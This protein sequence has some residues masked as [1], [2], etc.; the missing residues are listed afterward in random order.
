M[1]LN[2]SS[3]LLFL[4]QWLSTWEVTSCTARIMQEPNFCHDSCE[5]LDKVKQAPQG[6]VGLCQKLETLQWNYCASFYVVVTVIQIISMTQGTAL[7]EQSS[8]AFHCHICCFISQSEVKFPCGITVVEVWNSPYVVLIIK[9]VFILRMVCFLSFW[10]AIYN[11]VQGQW[12]KYVMINTVWYIYRSAIIQS[13]QCDISINVAVVIN[14]STGFEV[15]TAVRIC[16]VVW[17]RTRCN[18]VHTWIWMFWRSILGLSTQA[19]RMEAVRPGQIVCAD[20]LYC[21]V[22]NWEDHN[23]ES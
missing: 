12:K 7:I 21:T 15:L 5:N 13:S 1:V 20:H 17:V 19:I 3:G 23:F 11:S 6:A 2:L 4:C 9:Y 22:H 16:N 18:L 14:F 10:D 8:V